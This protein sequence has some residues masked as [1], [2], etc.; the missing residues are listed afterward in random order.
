MDH[1][2]GRALE[3]GTDRYRPTAAMIEQTGA[4]DGHCRGPCTVDARR[5]DIDHH[6]SGRRVPRSWAIWVPWTGAGTTS[7]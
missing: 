6:T 5:C 4:L 3:L 7:P 2:T 1:L